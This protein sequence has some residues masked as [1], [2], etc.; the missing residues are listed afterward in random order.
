MTV[1]VFADTSN[2]VVL[3]HLLKHTFGCAI[4]ERLAALCDDEP[5]L[6]NI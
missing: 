6:L 1:K 2:S 5:A 4:V 3:A